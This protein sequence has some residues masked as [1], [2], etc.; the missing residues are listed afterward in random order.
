MHQEM[1]EIIQELGTGLW[2]TLAFNELG[3]NQACAGD[4]GSAAERFAQAVQTGGGTLSF[5]AYVL[6]SQVNLALLGDRPAEALELARRY[7]R[8]VPQYR[9]FA[10]D[11][12]RAEGEALRRLGRVDEAETVLREARDA[13]RALR[14]EPPRWRACLAL[15]R[16]LE[17]RGR[18]AEAAA[19]YAE[20][21]QVLEAVGASLSDTSLRRFFTESAPF[22]EARAAGGGV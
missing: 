5:V 19:E 8:T 4:L 11:A 12:R 2:L 17:Q 13:A 21:R 14:A 20:A 1:L 18:P 16:L 7:E 22:R 6:L 15:G 9:V 3:E 10:A